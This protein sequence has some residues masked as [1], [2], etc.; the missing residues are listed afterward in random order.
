MIPDLE[1][2]FSLLRERLVPVHIVGHSVAV[3]ETAL[4]LGEALNAIGRQQNMALLA[5]A[6]VLHD[7]AKFATLKTGEDHAQVGADWLD[8]KGLKSVSWV[9]RH[10]VRLQLDMLHP[11]DEKELVFYADKRVQHERIVTLA[12]R[13][14]DLQ[15]RY[16]QNVAGLGSLEKMKEITLGLENKIFTGLSWL[17]DEMELKVNAVERNSS[18]QVGHY[19]QQLAEL[20]EKYIDNPPQI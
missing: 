8:E 2:S 17:P 7:I 15:D 9:V 14:I 4:L 3:A 20:Y 10:H 6:G 19:Y 12:Q 13:F 1:T 16:G 18:G 11:V 5:A